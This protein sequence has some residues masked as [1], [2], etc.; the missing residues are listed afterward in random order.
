MPEPPYNFR[1][2]PTS[3][4]LE[5]PFANY[6]YTTATSETTPEDWLPDGFCDEVAE[7]AV[8]PVLVAEDLEPEAEPALALEVAPGGATAAT[9][10]SLVQTD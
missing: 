4:T 5:T 7:A 9:L 3:S 6:E 8:E 10:E 1:Q 2:A